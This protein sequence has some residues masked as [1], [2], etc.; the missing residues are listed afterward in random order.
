MVRTVA[1]KLGENAEGLISQPDLFGRVA[2]EHGSILNYCHRG[3]NFLRGFFD[4]C[5]EVSN[6]CSAGILRIL[7]E[8]GCDVWL[9]SASKNGR[10]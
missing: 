10:Q 3:N 6:S 2:L 5:R 8:L 1:I 7:C 9:H 4:H